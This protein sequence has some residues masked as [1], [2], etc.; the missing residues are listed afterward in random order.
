MSQKINVNNLIIADMSYSF[1]SVD[2]Q[3]VIEKE[4][5]I[6]VPHVINI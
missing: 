3:L 4:S 5:V 1:N 2:L 6:S